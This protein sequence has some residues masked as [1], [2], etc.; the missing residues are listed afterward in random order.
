VFALSDSYG[1]TVAHRR[2]SNGDRV[3]CRRTLSLVKSAECE[4]APVADQRSKR[5]DAVAYGNES[6]AICQFAKFPSPLDRR[7][8]LLTSARLSC[9]TASRR[10]GDAGWPCAG[11]RQKMPSGEWLDWRRREGACAG[12]WWKVTRGQAV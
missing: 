9:Y 2:P 1:Q 7:E 10:S 8:M 11:V 4:V 12:R 5:S 3:A 6:T